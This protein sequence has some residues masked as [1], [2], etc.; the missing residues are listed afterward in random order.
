M[1]QSIR[2]AVRNRPEGIR[3]STS[4]AAAAGR[5][6]ATPAAV[7]EPL[8]GMRNDNSARHGAHLKRSLKLDRLRLSGLS[9]VRDEFLLAATA[10]NSR[11]MARKPAAENEELSLMPA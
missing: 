5:S 9:G 3:C 2:A 10:Q 6:C 1:T 11:K 8:A 7:R 4:V